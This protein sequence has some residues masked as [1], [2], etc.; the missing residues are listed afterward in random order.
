MLQK[1]KR[2]TLIGDILGVII[3]VLIFIIPF[4]EA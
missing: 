3:T 4:Y 2:K 1:E